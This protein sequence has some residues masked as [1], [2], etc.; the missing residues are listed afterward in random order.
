MDFRMYLRIKKLAAIILLFC[1]AP[2][3]SPGPIEE[4]R[5]DSLPPVS[6]VVVAV[7]LDSPDFTLMEFKYRVFYNK[8]EVKHIPLTDYDFKAAFTD[9]LLTAL[10]ED[11][12]MTWRK[13]DSTE[14]IDVPALW[15]RKV[16]PPK[17]EADRIL[18][19][20]IQG[21]GALTAS[22]DADIF[23][24]QARFRLVERASN[25]KLWEK[26]LFERIDLNGKITELQAD[27]Q[28]GLKEGIN[29]VLEKLCAKIAA[30]IRSANM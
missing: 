22:L 24:L 16:Q 18:L 5:I 12:R 7:Q 21:Y 14:V 2:F 8:S 28:K 23:F 20:Q 13:S 6:S 30:E 27:N 29:K 26:K 9:E 15:D 4:S 3:A 25:K 17:I 10:T 1:I 19:V 11:K